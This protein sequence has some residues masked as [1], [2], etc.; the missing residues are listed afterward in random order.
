MKILNKFVKDILTDNGN[1]S[2]ELCHFLIIFIVVAFVVFTA[3]TGFDAVKFGGGLASALSPIIAH[4]YVKN[5]T[6][7]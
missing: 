7:S 1:E 3:I 2:Y 4:L 6:D 5:K